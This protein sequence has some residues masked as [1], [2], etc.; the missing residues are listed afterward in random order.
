MPNNPKIDRVLARVEP[1][2]REAM[3]RILAGAAY[4]APVVASFSMASLDAVAQARCNNQSAP[5]CVDIPTTSPWTLAAMAGALG[6]VGAWFLR[7]RRER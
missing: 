4:T 6:A 1:G 2:R 3:R 5:T 7:R